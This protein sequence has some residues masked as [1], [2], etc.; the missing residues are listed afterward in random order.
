MIVR[1]AKW[2]TVKPNGPS[3]KGQPALLG[4]G[5]E[6]LGGMGGKFN[7][8][9]ISS[10][11]GKKKSAPSSGAKSSSGGTGQSRSRSRSTAG[12]QSPAQTSSA[13]SSL[14]P[15]KSVTGTQAQVASMAALNNKQTAAL[16]EYANEFQGGAYTEINSSLRSGG[17]LSDGARGIVEQMDS[18]FQHAQTQEQIT[19]Y[20]G[21][22]AAVAERLVAGASF[23]DPGFV[24]TSSDEKIARSF[25][26]G[27]ALM[28]V[29][30]PKGSR[31]LSM[32]DV[33]KDPDVG[34]EKEILLNRGG[35][36]R[37]VG[38]KDGQPPRIVVEYSS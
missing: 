22:P 18:A 16:A 37:V 30:V 21:V 6:V 1:D 27:G 9:K 14:D 7:G 17:E 29:V 36:F 15:S 23:T 20:R 2:I 3:K 25:A 26:G 32:W 5:G 12:Q 28:E 24:S 38:R 33:P 4:E 34:D 8:Q 10:V 31:A 11:G 19:V 35:S 13:S